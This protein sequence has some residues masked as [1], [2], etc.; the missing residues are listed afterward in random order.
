VLV[1]QGIN[2]N[3]TVLSNVMDMLENVLMLFV[4]SSEF[5]LLYISCSDIHVHTSYIQVFIYRDSTSEWSPGSEKEVDGNNTELQD[6]ANELLKSVD[7]PRFTYSKV[8]SGMSY[9]LYF[10]NLDW[11]GIE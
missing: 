10:F 1:R 9:N 4:L 3:D 5:Y 7:D 11:N 2:L 8:S 6:T